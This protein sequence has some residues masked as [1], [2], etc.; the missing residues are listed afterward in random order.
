MPKTFSK[1]QKNH[2]R[3]KSSRNWNGS[4]LVPG[5]LRRMAASAGLKVNEL[6]AERTVETEMVTANCL[7][8]W[9]VIP[10]IKV[11]GIKTAHNTR[12]TAIT[13]PVTS[14]IAL[15]AA[16][17]GVAPLCSHLSTFSTT[18][19]AS[20]TTIPIAS[21]NPKSEML[22][23]EYPSRAITAKVPMIATGTA[24]RGIRVARQLCKKTKTTIPTRMIASRRVLKT[25]AIDSLI[26]GV[27]S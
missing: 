15:R 23:M 20:S 9:P 24:M 22:L 4:F 16:S 5:G 19:I 26:K 27:V 11:H 17:R 14:F 25:S 3:N 8:N 6:I 7:K 10:L 1:S 13:G 21:T 12:A 18:T 2:P